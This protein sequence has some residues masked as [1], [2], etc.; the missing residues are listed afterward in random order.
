M[1]QPLK[2]NIDVDSDF[3]L[4]PISEKSREKHFAETLN[5][6]SLKDLT[7]KQRKKEASKPIYLVRYE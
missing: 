4:M 1:R 5:V 6:N 2:T 3:S 7:L